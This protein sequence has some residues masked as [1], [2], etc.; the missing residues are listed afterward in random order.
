MA[1]SAYVD[2]VFTFYRGKP[3]TTRPSM[4]DVVIIDD[5]LHQHT[6]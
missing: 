5:N 1:I 6:Q 2:Q 4:K 3:I